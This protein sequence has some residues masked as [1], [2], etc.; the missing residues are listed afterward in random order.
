MLSQSEFCARYILAHLA[1]RHPAQWLSSPR[2]PR[3]SLTDAISSTNLL[4]EL[5]AAEIAVSFRQSERLR[6]LDTV[7][8]LFREFYFRGVALDSHEGLVGWLEQRYPLRLLFHIPTPDEMLAYQCEGRRYVTVLLADEDQLRAHGRH[9]DAC[10]FLLHDL[11]HAHK[12]FADPLVHLG[13]VRFFRRLRDSLDTFML[14][15]DDLSF[16]KDLNYLKSDM[17]SHPV[18]LIKFLKAV[19]LA[20][21]IRR[22]GQR[23]PDLRDFWFGLFLRWG[24]ERDLLPCAL[25]INHPEVERPEHLVAVSEFFVGDNLS[26]GS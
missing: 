5:S 10:D 1:R 13:Q 18:H 26:G 16:A 17:N 21:E 12:F 2:A 7:V 11:E 4:C 25:S 15:R 6:G 24:M 3:A 20:A 23:Y 8:D 9:A 22:T 19:V 14:W